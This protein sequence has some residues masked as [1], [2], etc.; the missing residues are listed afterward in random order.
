MKSKNS[1]THEFVEQS[2]TSEST[3]ASSAHWFCWQNPFTSL[4]THFNSGDYPQPKD[5]AILETLEEVM[6]IEATLSGDMDLDYVA[7]RIKMNDYSF[8]CSGLWLWQVRRYKSYLDTHDNFKDWC[9]DVVR[10]DYTTV[11]AMI[12]AALVW[13][14]LVTMG[15]EILPTSIAQCVVM[16]EYIRDLDE[17]SKNWQY[18]IDNLEPHEF[19]KK[20]IKALL[21][22]EIKKTNTTLT[23]PLKLFQN[24]ERT[25][26]NCGI[27]IIKLVEQMYEQI[28][29]KVVRTQPEQMSR[30][31]EDLALIVKEKDTKEAAETAQQANRVSPAT[32]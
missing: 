9:K 28:F 19:S 2:A 10:K 17:F 3:N 6:D 30:W 23:F 5:T 29:T 31:Y 21:Q 24:L 12:K 13:V 27:S 26:L 1:A 11:L 8:V 25:A 7:L 18:V 20:N 15:F 14:Q 32:S 22:G 4:Y 16:Y